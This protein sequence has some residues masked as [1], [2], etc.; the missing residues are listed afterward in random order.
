MI[1]MGEPKVLVLNHENQEEEVERNYPQPREQVV[2]RGIEKDTLVPYMRVV[3][4]DHEHKP[5]P[6]NMQLSVQVAG[7]VTLKNIQ[8]LFCQVCKYVYYQQLPDTL[9]PS[10]LSLVPG[11][12]KQ[13]R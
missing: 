6:F 3:E 1:D 10:P 4:R 5:L 12:G 2:I 13:R 11:T 7:E 9:P 8:L